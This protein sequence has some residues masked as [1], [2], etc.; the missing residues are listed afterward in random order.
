MRFL[1]LPWAA[2]LL[3]L[4]QVS[5]GASSGPCKAQ[6]GPVSLF[7]RCACCTQD[8]SCARTLHAWR[9]LSS[10]RPSVPRTMPRMGSAISDST[11]PQKP[12]SPTASSAGTRYL[13]ADEV[14]I[15]RLWRRPIL[16]HVLPGCKSTESSILYPGSSAQT[17]SHWWVARFAVQ[18]PGAAGCLGRAFKKET[19]Q[20]TSSNRPLTWRG[21]FPP[22]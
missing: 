6:G 19:K 3:A 12:S 22:Q 18:Q 10:G 1:C 5:C 8:T 13:H 2:A 7:A 9:A 17:K 16:K 15:T 20:K 14:H 4:R 11:S 21:T